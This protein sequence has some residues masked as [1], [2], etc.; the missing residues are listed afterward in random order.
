MAEIPTRVE[1]N[2]YSYSFNGWL[3]YSQGS[4]AVSDML[5]TADYSSTDVVYSAI[6]NTGGGHFNDG[7]TT[8]TVT[9]KYNE[10]IS[11]EKPVREDGQIF[12]GWSPATLQ[13]SG[14]NTYTAQYQVSGQLKVTFDASLVCVYDSSSNKVLE[15][16]PMGS[17]IT[18]SD[19]Q[20]SKSYTGGFNEIINLPIGS[21]ATSYTLVVFKNGNRVTINGTTDGSKMYFMG[22]CR[23]N[24]MATRLSAYDWGNNIKTETINDSSGGTSKA[25]KYIPGTIRFGL[26]TYWLNEDGVIQQSPEGYEITFA[27]YIIIN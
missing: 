16:D 2:Y 9:G 27:P 24:D 4:V 21:F 10:F 15:V 22:D 14:N 20:V 12:A 23:S 3:G 17:S 5:F 8:R 1:D 6:F 18:Y 25:V 26:A 13:L 19:G 11:I 7:S